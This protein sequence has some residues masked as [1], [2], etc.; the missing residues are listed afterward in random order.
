MKHDFTGKQ[1]GLIRIERMLSAEERPAGPKRS[2]CVCVCTGCGRTRTRPLQSVLIA[3]R[4]PRFTTGCTPCTRL[5]T[6][7]KLDR[8]TAIANRHAAG[9][10][11]QALAEEFGITR[12][13][14][15]QIAAS[16]KQ[17]GRGTSPY[18]GRAK[19]APCSA[20]S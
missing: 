1:F 6:A 2:W 18:K 7:V 20:T 8:N 15:G 11:L 16:L 9:E 12:A 17:G 5:R 19:V 3:V 14:V 10:T 4:H 13:R